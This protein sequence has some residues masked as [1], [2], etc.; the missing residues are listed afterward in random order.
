MTIK[1][2][3]FQ[4]RAAALHQSA[5]AL[6]QKNKALQEQAAAEKAEVRAKSFIATGKRSS[7]VFK[8]KQDML[9]ESYRQNFETLLTK[10]IREAC[11]VDISEVSDYELT[12][13]IN[14]VRDTFTE[15]INENAIVT[16]LAPVSSGLGINAHPMTMVLD[17]GGAKNGTVRPAEMIRAMASVVTDQT[18]RVTLQ[19][20]QHNSVNVID[21]DV[22]NGNDAYTMERCLADF[23]NFTTPFAKVVQTAV[24]TSLREDMKNRELAKEN[25]LYEGMSAAARQKTE[26]AMR[27]SQK[28]TLLSEVF[29][30]VK[31]LNEDTS[32]SSAEDYLNEAVFNTTVLET[33]KQLNM[34]TMTQPEIALKLQQKRKAFVS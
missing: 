32:T 33:L 22:K 14:F 25:M 13:Q 21:T 30:T 34:I 8:Q 15:I 1:T 31:T 3:F 27:S 26:A 19:D 20:H 11:P 12:E 7:A 28:S 5:E 16:R 4:R 10:I 2:S 17:I 23:S 24:L 18:V 29:A 9:R 6:A